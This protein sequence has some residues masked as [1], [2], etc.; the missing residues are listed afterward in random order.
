ME[1]QSFRS[2]RRGAEL[3][4]DW[5]RRKLAETGAS[6]LFLPAGQSVEPLYAFWEETKPAYL[7][8]VVLVQVDDVADGRC[9]GMFLEFLYEHLPS[10]RDQIV[11]V[12]E[13]EEPA[14]L[15]LLGFG[16]NGHVAFH[17]PGLPEDLRKAVVPLSDETIA[18]L[19]LARG[20]HGV[21]FGVGAFLETAASLLLVAGAGKAEAFRA[22][23]SGD[24][25][26][27][28]ARLQAHPDLLVLVEEAV[29][30]ESST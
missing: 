11:P 25:A 21:T 7:D 5:C 28:A 24:P 10:Y 23:L 8:A 20:T 15:T 6:S 26:L 14:E 19:D 18:R 9:E 17:E 2:P 29:L 16:T 3:A 27:P 13:R 22:F 30:R 1:L 12:S 4:S